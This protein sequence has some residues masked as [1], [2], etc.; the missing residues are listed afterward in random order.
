MDKDP[1]PPTA[2][3]TFLHPSIESIF[4]T[5][6]GQLHVT[7]TSYVLTTVFIVIVLAIGCCCY[8]NPSC[9]N[10]FVTKITALQEKLYV[11]FTS[12]EFR[13]KR[14]LKDLNDKVNSNWVQIERME[15]LIAKKSALLAKL[16]ANS[17]PSRPAP[18]APS[19]SAPLD[20]PDMATAEIHSAPVRSS[21][22]VTL[23]SQNVRRN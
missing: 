4:L 20:A 10:C 2:Q 6:A 13:D 16:P 9:R 23:G 15:G 11:K 5:P 21:S 22:A 14:E 17:P 12:K 3:F 1:I 8:K 18:P 7:N 19:A